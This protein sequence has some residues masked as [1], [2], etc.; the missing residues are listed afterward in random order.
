MYIKT[1]YLEHN[2]LFFMYKMESVYLPIIHLAN[3]MTMRVCQ[4]FIFNNI[5]TSIY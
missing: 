3:N 2:I 4:N 1:L 5:V